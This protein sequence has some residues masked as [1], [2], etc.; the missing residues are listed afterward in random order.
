MPEVVT[1]REVNQHTSAAFQRVRDGAELIV[2][3]AGQPL[4]RIIP[5][6]PRDAYERLV[7]D[8]RIVPAK[9]RRRGPVQAFDVPVD[10]DA[11]VADDRAERWS[12]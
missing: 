2:T 3:K 1:I 9:N 12:R 11:L 4:A 5:F 7:S 8:G 10:V 6:Q